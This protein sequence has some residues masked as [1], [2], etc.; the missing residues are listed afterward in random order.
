S[1]H[2]R[3]ALLRHPLSAS[4]RGLSTPA[5]RSL[6]LPDALPIYAHRGIDD[7]V[8]DLGVLGGTTRA[9]AEDQ[10]GAGGPG[11]RVVDHHRRAGVLQDRKSTRLNSSHVKI[12]Y[13]VSCLKKKT[14]N[15]AT[16]TT[17]RA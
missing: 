7:V 12:S 17:D 14:N 15:I 16:L 2:S 13:A 9:A 1:R 6:S 3:V 5:F 11:H 8:A 4:L 10:A